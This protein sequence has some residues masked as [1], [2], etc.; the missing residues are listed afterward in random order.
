[1]FV[2]LL[3]KVLTASE[4]NELKRGRNFGTWVKVTIADMSIFT[5]NLMVIRFSNENCVTT[6]TGDDNEFHGKDCSYSP[7]GRRGLSDCAFEIRLPL[8]PTH[9]YVV[10]HNTDITFRVNP[11]SVFTITNS[12][13]S[14]FVCVQIWVNVY[15]YTFVISF[16]NVELLH[17]WLKALVE[18]GC[19]FVVCSHYLHPRD[20]LHLFSHLRIALTVTPPVYKQLYFGNRLRHEAPAVICTPRWV[21]QSNLATATGHGKK[22]T[23]K[24]VPEVKSRRGDVPNSLRFSG[25]IRCP[26]TATELTKP[27]VVKLFLADAVGSF[28]IFI[29]LGKICLVS[30]KCAGITYDFCAKVQFLRRRKRTLDCMQ[31]ESHCDIHRQRIEYLKIL[32]CKMYHVM[33]RQIWS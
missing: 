30:R 11:V 29:V 13:L 9:P 17:A 22:T 8:N 21:M 18:S 6:C 31:F 7:N 27:S 23:A 24:C 1:M 12:T 5:Q 4:I 2:K 28:P 10:S 3:P 33:R 32:V 19:V 16:W 25:I 20:L 15:N 14:K 26:P